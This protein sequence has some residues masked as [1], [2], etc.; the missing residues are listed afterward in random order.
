MAGT[1]VARNEQQKMKKNR[2]T[3][4]AKKKLSEVLREAFARLDVNSA[5]ELCHYIPYNNQRLHHLTFKKMQKEDPETL[6][7]LVHQNV[8]ESEP[9]KLPPVVRKK[10]PTHQELNSAIQKA[11]EKLNLSEQEEEKLCHYMPSKNGRYLHPL[12]YRAIKRKAPQKLAQEITTY[13]LN[14]EKPSR[15]LKSTKRVDHDN[16]ALEKSPSSHNELF[17]PSQDK[18]AFQPPVGLF[19]EISQLTNLL[20]EFKES[21]QLE[22]KRLPFPKKH[23]QYIQNE[24]VRKIMNQEAD[25]GLWEIFKELIKSRAV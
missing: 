4:V 25:D 21:I 6:I 12:A 13:I 14:Q 23:L 7:K 5:A 19:K 2:K 16:S 9:T 20:G 15:I 24:L 1:K 18:A 22:T 8:L 3:P 17:S 10:K 11:L